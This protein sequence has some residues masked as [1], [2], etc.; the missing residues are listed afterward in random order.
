MLSR[1]PVL[2]PLE[3]LTFTRK[4]DL[5]LKML[6][7]NHQRAKDQLQVAISYI[8]SLREAAV[9]YACLGT[10][11]AGETA[12]KVM[13][14]YDDLRRSVARMRELVPKLE[15]NSSK[16]LAQLAFQLESES[17]KLHT[18]EFAKAQVFANHAIAVF[19][20]LRPD[21]AVVDPPLGP[22]PSLCDDSVE[23]DQPFVYTKLSKE[24]ATLLND[25]LRMR[26]ERIDAIL[27]EAIPLRKV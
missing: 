2:E 21:G 4:T 15:P 6:S 17:I 23:E 11:V 5:D 24:L 16:A 13:Q 19:E 22:P 20:S 25:H 18:V 26:V 9:Y 10:P 27:P 12:M 3:R 8:A 1:K 7:E 14:C